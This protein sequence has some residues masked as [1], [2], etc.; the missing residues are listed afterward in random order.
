LKL[1]DLAVFTTFLYSTLLGLSGLVL[2]KA[3]VF[4]F[5]YVHIDAYSFTLVIFGVVGML[6]FYRYGNTGIALVLIAGG[7]QE[8][9]WTF[10]YELLHPG[11]F[12]D[13]LLNPIPDYIKYGYQWSMVCAII[14]GIFLWH[15]NRGFLNLSPDSLFFPCYVA[16]YVWI[17]MPTIVLDR[18][19]PIYEA[20]YVLM[21]FVFVI[22]TFRLRKVNKAP[23]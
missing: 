18:A 1:L 7:I 11:Y 21:C 14:V 22:S 12:V 3:R 17:G 9:S 2:G 10:L 8:I 20:L 19:S 16:F 6:M 13:S 23:V 15:K 4:Y 5:P